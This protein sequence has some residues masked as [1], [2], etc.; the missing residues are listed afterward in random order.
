MKEKII[1]QNSEFIKS[2]IEKKEFLIDKD[3]ILFVGRSNAGKSTLINALSFKKDLMRVASMPGKTRMINYALIDSSF[4]FVDSPGYGFEKNRSYFYKLMDD[5]FAV[6]EG[7]LKAIVIVID[8]RR[9][10]LSSDEIMEEYAKSYNIP[11][12]YAFTKSDK[13]NRSQ[14]R[15][16]EEKFKL[17]HPKEKICFVSTSNYDKYQD[18]RDVIVDC[19]VAK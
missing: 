14:I 17:S 6:S 1:F 9:G 2:A 12:I 11:I 13:L 3:C 4:Y 18:L 15:Q 10:I 5:Y 7:C 8:A 19:L 16:S